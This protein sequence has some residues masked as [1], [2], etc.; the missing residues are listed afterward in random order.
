MGQGI[1][2]EN[3]EVEALEGI[4]LDISESKKME[5]RLR[6][7]NEHDKWTGL[8]NRDHL[9]L[10]LNRDIRKKDG[11]RRA[12]MSI[13]LSTVQLL[14]ANYGFHYTQ[15]LIKEAAETL[16]QYCSDNRMLF[17]TYENRFVFYLINYKDKNEL[18]DFGDAIAKS[19]ETLFVTD[20]I[21]GGIGVFEIEQAIMRS[22]LIYF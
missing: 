16:S 14:T 1:Y 20:R 19:L 4:I 12:V 8:Y 6:Y 17:Q 15:C 21:G 3:G 22:M 7:L 10:L 11:L 13:N 5:N 18:V 9:E 2:N